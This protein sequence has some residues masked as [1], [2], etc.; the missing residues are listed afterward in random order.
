MKKIIVMLA[1]CFATAMAF[2]ADS[3]NKSTFELRLVAAA[4]S[5]DTEP[6]TI[7]YKGRP[8]ETVNVQKANILDQSAIK[9]ATVVKNERGDPAL[10][11]TLTEAGRQRFAEFTRQ[12]TGKRIAMI[13]NGRACSAPVIQTP[14][15][16]GKIRIS[17]NFTLEEAND[18]IRGIND[19]WAK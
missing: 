16:D 19:T 8:A 10:E 14:I 15:T 1:V 4:P 5:A 9:S 11:I 12:N 13:I 7:E 18:L 17:G 6:M 3:T 2:A